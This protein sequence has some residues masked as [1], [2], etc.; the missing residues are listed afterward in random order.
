MASN[1]IAIYLPTLH[2]GGAERVMI[3]L[4][5]R[6]ADRGYDIELVVGNLE[7][8]FRNDIDEKVQL[9][10]LKSPSLSGIPNIGQ[11]FTLINY[12][13][14]NS[15]SVVISSMKHVNVLLLC[16]HKISNSKSAVII[17]E[18]N[19]PVM[20]SDSSM[21]N[22]AIYKLASVM[23]RWADAVIAV[24]EGV[25]TNLSEVIGIPEG[26][27]DVIHN[28]VVTGELIDSSKENP[29]HHWFNKENSVIM[30]V[31]RLTEQK[32]YQLLLEAFSD[33]RDSSNCKLIIIGRGEKED[34][35]MRYSE[36]LGIEE[37]IEIINWVDNPYSYMSSADAFVLT[38]KWEG[39]PTVLIEALACRCPVISADCPSGPREI[40]CDGKYGTLVEVPTSTNFSEA[41]KQTIEKPQDNEG[42]SRALD[43]TLEECVDNYEELML[44]RGFI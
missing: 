14:S 42:F 27:I 22:K 9:T 21:K 13:R 4:A 26:R 20:V 1:D 17:T 28:P 25:A 10:D 23:Y 34:D 7:G 35:L 8:E 3:Y 32:N 33:L 5:N 19:D 16:A 38:S 24:S 29:D 43:F 36:Q 30:S 40:L 37:H 39:L 41:I 6:L 2:S 15:P 11:F 12:F 44:E 31:G 18:H